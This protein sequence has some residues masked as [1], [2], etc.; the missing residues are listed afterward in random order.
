MSFAKLFPLLLCILVIIAQ[1]A[2]ITCNL[3]YMS[4]R[5]AKQPRMGM[6]WMIPSHGEVVGRRTVDA[7][8]GSDVDSGVMFAIRIKVETVI[9]SVLPLLARL[10]DTSLRVRKR[11]V[12]LLKSLLHA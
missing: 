4:G 7:Q 8:N 3:L 1:E 9:G 11:V 12:R 10:Q 2:G 6:H 5:I